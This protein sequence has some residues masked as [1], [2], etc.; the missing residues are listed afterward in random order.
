L[1]ACR[2]HGV[3]PK[4]LVEIPYRDFQHAFP[5]EPE[6]ALRRFERID[7]ARRHILESVME[8]WHEICIQ[9]EKTGYFFKSGPK[10]ETIIE[11][12]SNHYSTVL[13]IQAARFRKIEKNQWKTLQKMLFQEMKKAVNDQQGKK[14]LL[15]QETMHGEKLALK[16]RMNEEVEAKVRREIEAAKKKEEDLMMEIKE[17]QKYFTEE[18]Y[19]KKLQ[20]EE[21]LRQEKANQNRREYERLRREKFL[22]QHKEESR[23]QTRLDQDERYRQLELREAETKDRLDA[24]RR[25]KEKAITDKREATEAQVR[26]AQ[27][28]LKEQAK[29][30]VDT[31]RTV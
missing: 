11:V 18:A 30:R 5:G 29:R 2:L 24:E 23:L 19:L 3:E 26:N 20:E 25:E 21:D 14:V 28:V 31:V 27:S 9:E 16:K 10:G 6:V 12:D 13:E 7:A 4:E 17:A 22:K 1:E 15:R 8:K